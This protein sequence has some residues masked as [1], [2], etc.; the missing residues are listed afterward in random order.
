MTRLD[1]YLVLIE[2]ERD[3]RPAEAMLVD[4]IKRLRSVSSVDML[5]RAATASRNAQQQ[6]VG[7][8]EWFSWVPKHLDQC[9]DRLETTP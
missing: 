3:S 7:K 6:M 8:T 5:R 4:E 1:D 2:Q 9:A